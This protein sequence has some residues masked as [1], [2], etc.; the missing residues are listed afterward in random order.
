[1]VNAPFGSHGSAI[2]PNGLYTIGNTVDFFSAGAYTA[3]VAALR[4]TDF[5]RSAATSFC[6]S[7]GR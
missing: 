5:R 2:V 7:R 6:F 4:S 1:L 3:S